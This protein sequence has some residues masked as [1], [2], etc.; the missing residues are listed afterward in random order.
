MAYADYNDLMKMT[1]DLF[2]GMVK[3]ITGSYVISIQRE[4]NSDPI[5]IDFSP[6]F[7]RIS[8]VSAI[9]EA[10]NST[11]PIGDPEKCLQVLEELVTKYELEC[12]SPRSIARLLDKLVAHFIEDNV[13]N[14]TK[15]FFICDHPVLMSPLA[16]YHRSKPHL[17]ERFELFLAGSE[18][19]NAYTELNNPVYV[20]II[21]AIY[22]Y[23]MY[24]VQRE[25]F[26]EQSQQAA[27][28]DDEAQPHDEGFC[29][30]MEYGLPPTGGW[31][32]GVDRITMFLT[33]KFNIKE[34][35]L[36]PAMKPEE[37]GSEGA[38]ASCPNAA[39][40]K[41]LETTLS[42][43]NFINGSKPSSSDA[44]WFSKIEALVSPDLS[45]FPKVQVW[46]ELVG[47]FPAS[48]RSTW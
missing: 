40:L 21:F 41:S 37:Q 39:T 25:R 7:K 22:I 36:F 28:G 48:V 38:D 29:T 35:L 4:P 14:W 27:A 45:K 16:K 46:H 8:M 26:I 33:N 24:R 5:E 13:E 2:S 19:C 34:V 44:E 31:G 15:P 32:C 6:P 1:E 20:S 3:A 42:G 9:E 11:I 18:I 47:Y 10:T 23:V 30:A 12:S 43:E 17:T